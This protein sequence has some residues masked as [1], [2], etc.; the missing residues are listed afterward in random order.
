MLEDLPLL[1][2]AA[3]LIL[4]EHRWAIPLRDKMAAA[5]GFPIDAGMISPLDLAEIG[6]ISAVEAE[7]VA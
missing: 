2:T 7:A 4:L 6:L 3:A 5:R 1:D